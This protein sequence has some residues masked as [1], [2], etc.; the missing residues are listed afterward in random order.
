MLTDSYVDYAFALDLFHAWGDLWR[1]TFILMLIIACV[2][3]FFL[4]TAAD[5]L[6]AF[7]WRRRYRTPCEACEER[8]VEGSKG[9]G[10]RL[11]WSRRSLETLRRLCRRG[12]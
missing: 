1:K 7:I 4:G 5:S 3:G 12:L 11:P 6:N 9:E 10:P 2:F 8:R